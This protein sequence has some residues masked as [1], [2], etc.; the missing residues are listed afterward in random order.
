MIYICIS[1]LF[2][3]MATH[4]I[5]KFLP[6]LRIILRTKNDNIKRVIEQLDNNNVRFLCEC[7]LNILKG[8][9]PLE[10]KSRQKAKGFKPLYIKLSKKKTPLKE[11][12]QVMMD[13]PSF[14]K[15]FVRMTFSTF[16]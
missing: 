14:V 3:A 7:A 12:R 5:E 15:S 10:E 8:I 4:Y 6:L 16:N 9:I 11:K 2:D 13:N 1:H